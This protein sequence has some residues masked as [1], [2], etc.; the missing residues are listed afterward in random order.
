M[1]C[2]HDHNTGMINSYDHPKPPQ[3][4]LVTDM[5]IMKR[6][7]CNIVINLFIP[8]RIIKPNTLSKFEKFRA[9][10]IS[11]PFKWKSWLGSEMFRA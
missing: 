11:K 10:V 9:S 1:F 5:S 4:G 6:I 2:S 3:E 8:K 7:H